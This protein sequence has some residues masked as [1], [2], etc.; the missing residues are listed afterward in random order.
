[1]L[2]VGGCVSPSQW[3]VT[4]VIPGE[5]RRRSAGESLRFQS[6]AVGVGRSGEDEQPFPM[7]W[8]ADVG[9]S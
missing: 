5:R 4:V 8:G 7:V 2:D 1:M 3:V 6:D 9:S